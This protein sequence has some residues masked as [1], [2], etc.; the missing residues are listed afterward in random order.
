MP[1]FLNDLMKTGFNALVKLTIGFSIGTGA[2]A[3]VCWYYGIP[4]VLS[5]IGAF[6]YWASRLRSYRIQASYREGFEHSLIGDIT[7]R[8]KGLAGVV[9][10]GC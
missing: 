6:S 1:E 9:A 3:A 7:T 10:R 5:I 2:G 8:C 4:M